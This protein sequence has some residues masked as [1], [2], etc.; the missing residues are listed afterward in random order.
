VQLILGDAVDDPGE[1]GQHGAQEFSGLFGLF[2]LCRHAVNVGVHRGEGLRI[3]ASSDAIA[4][5]SLP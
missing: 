4:I 5:A 1:V 2:G 3:R